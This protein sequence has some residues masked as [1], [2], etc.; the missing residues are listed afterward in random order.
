MGPDN[1]AVP[2]THFHIELRALSSSPY[3][4]Q[5]QHPQRNPQAIRH[6]YS[7]HLSGNR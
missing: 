6:A 2:P 4:G 5:N 1:T 3:P 7:R